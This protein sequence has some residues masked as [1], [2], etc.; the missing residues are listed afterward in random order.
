MRRPP[1]SSLAIAAGI[2]LL[3][4]IWA[5]KRY[6]PYVGGSL[7]PKQPPAII[8]SMNDAYFVGMKNK[9]KIWSLKAKKVDISRNRSITSLSGITDGKIF[10]K[11]KA[12]FQVQ[13][14]QAT[15]NSL[16]K[17]LLLDDGINIQGEDGQ[18]LSARY[19]EWN[20][21]TSTLRS[22]GRVMFTSKWSKA[23]AE[24]L[25]VNLKTR[26]MT[27]WHTSFTI[28]LGKVGNQ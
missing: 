24:K 11:G 18:R 4:S 22:N 6:I 21:T 27:L 28:D 16:D 14:G 1:Y 12:V 23:S 7:A 3:L 5:F 25:I 13:A 15:Y 8:L 26:E 9:D 2:I 10:N 19:A 17:K 20:S